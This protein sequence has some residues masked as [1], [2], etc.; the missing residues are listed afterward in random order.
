[1][2]LR[3][4]LALSWLLL[5]AHLAAQDTLALDI[6][7]IMRGVETVGR[8][9]SN[10]RW[11][12]DG[13]WIYFSW[14]PP[15]TDWRAA[16][17]PY[18]VRARSGATPEAVSPAAMDSVAP[19]LAGG[20][21]SRD[22]RHKYVGSGGDLWVVD[23]PGGATRRLTRTAAGEQ[24][25]GLSVDEQ[26]LYYRTDGNLFAV[27]LASGDV[28]QLTDVR[29]GT[30]PDTTTRLSPQERALVR[31]QLELLETIRDDAWQD[32]VRRVARA[33]ERADALPTVWLG[34][35][36]RLRSLSLSPTG[37]HAI[38]VTTRSAGS[39][40]KRTMVPR[41][42][43]ASGYTEEIPGRT[44]VGDPESIQRVGVLTI[45][46]GEVT[47]LRPVPDDSTD[48]YAGLG[49][50]GWNDA[51]T[52][53]L[54][55]TETTGHTRQV[56]SRI[57]TLGK[58]VVQHIDTDSAWVGGPCGSCAGWLPGDAG[59][60]FV[61]EADGY[62]HLYRMPVDGTPRQLTR[63]PWEVLQA[64][65]SDDR[66][67]FELHTSEVS[68]FE[69]N[70]Y[71]MDL[72]GTHRQQL[73]AGGGGHSVTVSPDG[74]W[75]ADV[76]STANHPEELYL[77]AATPGATASRLTHSPLP[78]WEAR[79]WIAPEIVEIPASDGV[80]VPAR[81]FRPEQMG[82]TPNG[83]AVLFVHGAGYLHNVHN[84]WSSYFR[85][86]QFHHLLATRGYV[87]LDVDYRGSAGYGR[88]W[89]TA[90]YRHM[91]GRDLED[92]VD[93]SKWLTDTM[94]I[95]GDRIGIY[96]GSYGGF[97]TLMALFTRG[98]YFGAGAALRSVTDWAH[99]NDGYTAPILN[100]PATDSLAYHR[101][102]PIYFAEGLND[103]LLM[104]H[105]MVDTNVHFQDI[106]RLT[107]RLIELGKQ[108]WQLAVYPVENHG[109]ERPDSWTDEYRRILD[110][111]D[112]WLP[113]GSPGRD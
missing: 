41:F 38:L 85:E 35:D 54:V 31:D 102:S 77:Q 33:T 106:V 44:K 88:D 56:M 73:T 12:P 25:V 76:W 104:A 111:F 36:T 79:H 74:R 91:G 72:D 22:G 53:A 67:H 101:S 57:D 75:L 92:F 4:T 47:W 1:M 18:R 52:A 65:L 6:P 3:S 81:I 93:A 28:A 50:R 11:T 14:A 97:L 108:H 40:P 89:R 24:P 58:V 37:R 83:A 96:G 87:V 39:A 49:V 34:R 30:A 27:T 113:V 70:Y 98:E 69:R 32:S 7:T 62:A 95:P 45:A 94:H 99:Y 26:T 2:A 8:T 61:S 17:E 29:T 9:P 5:P 86:Y 71:T 64:S 48:R 107:Q 90:I 78:A 66:Q 84:Y 16:S 19:L 42:V 10:L 68:P 46:T 105:G 60:W 51:G 110:L 43:T 109:F 23:L 21:L 100:E 59:L 15:G 80:R 55:I 112:R 63:G 82:A 13:K 20:I 103:P